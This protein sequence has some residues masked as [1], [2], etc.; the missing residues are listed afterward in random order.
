[1]NEEKKYQLWLDNYFFKPSF[2]QK[3]L[4]F[5]FLPLSLLYGLCAILNTCFRQKIDFKKPIISVGNL[6]FGGNGKTPICKAIAREFEG[7]F[8]VLRGYRRKSKG[9]LVVKNENAILAQVSQSGDEAMEYA[10][11][12]CVKGVIV[13]EDRVA[14]IQ[15]AFELGAKIVLLDDAFSKFHIQNLIF[16]LKARSS[17]I[18]I[19]PY[20]AVLIVCLN[21]MKKKLIL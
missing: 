8:I 12:E 3:C 17:L 11:E 9:L 15:K 20:Q 6:S 16:C 1:M 21:F 13:S 2:F 18:L 14:G 4:A 10:F 5:I 19:L 7:V